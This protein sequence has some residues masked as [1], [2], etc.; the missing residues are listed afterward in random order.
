M[1]NPWLAQPRTLHSLTDLG[2]IVDGDGDD[3]I[4]RVSE[5]KLVKGT[6]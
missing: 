4:A 3:D 1:R 2:A 5:V 6:L